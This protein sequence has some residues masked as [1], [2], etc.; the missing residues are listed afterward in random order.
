MSKKFFIF[1]IVITLLLSVLGFWYWKRNIYS[2]EVLK[3]EVLGSDRPAA[4]EEVEYVVKYKNNGNIALEDI[5]LIFEYPKHAILREGEQQRKV[6]MGETLYPGQERTFSFRARL[7]GGEGQAVEARA[8]ISY[9]P[10]NLKA[11]YESTTSHTAVISSVPLTLGFDLPSNVESGR[12]FTF[13]VNYFSQSDY[14]INN[15]RLSMEYPKGFRFTESKPRGLDINEWDIGLLNKAE[16]G[17]IEVNGTVEGETGTQQ[18]FR[19]KL[20]IW[21]EGEFVLLKDAT[22]AFVIAKPSLYIVQQ[23][24]GTQNYI[25]SPGD[26][27]HYEIYFRNAGESPFENLFLAVRLEGEVYDFSAL[28]VGDGTSQQGDNSILWDW[29]TIPQLRYLGPGQEGK[30]EFWVKLKDETLLPSGSKNLVARD[31]VIFPSARATFETK[32]KGGLRV[33]QLVYF[34]DS[35]FN[36]KGPVP[37][38]I[39]EATTYTVLWRAQALRNDADNVKVKARLPENVRPTA[40]VF[41]ENAKITFDMQSREIV[42]EV[43]KVETGISQDAA[44]SAAFQIVLTPESKDVG[45]TVALVGDASISGIDLWTGAELEGV[46]SGRDTSLP[47]DPTIGEGQ[48]IVR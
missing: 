33:M 24:N 46:A 48:G 44:P 6:I 16:G 34:Q 27:L 35:I 14:P 13:S 32:I 45:N 20:G 22:R 4:F 23:I 8:S 42:W 1:L 31:T 39:G 36:N 25:A 2:K 38:K 17:R 43:G 18:L 26:F 10:K 9:R 40:K 29:Q 21:D 12:P 37:P 30:V 41:P 28:R 47:D 19:A 11:R 3:L 7:I 5:R 15:L